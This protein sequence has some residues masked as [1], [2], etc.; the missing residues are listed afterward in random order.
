MNEKLKRKRREAR[1]TQQ[2]LAKKCG[3]TRAT[4]NSIE[5]G[6]HTCKV[7]VALKIA[8]ALKVEISEIFEL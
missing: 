6:R 4:I 2:Q 8:K 1:L 5:T 7:F 3:V